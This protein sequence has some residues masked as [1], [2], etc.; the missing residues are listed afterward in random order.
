MVIGVLAL[1]GDFDAHRKMLEGCAGVTRVVPVRAPA[2]LRECDGLILPGG[3][4]T[5]MSRLCDRYG[6]W[7]PL[8][9]RLEQGMGALGTCAGL[10]LL[11]K[12]IEGG[13]RNFLQKT[14]G[15]LDVDVARNAYGAQLDSFEADVAFEGPSS[16]QAEPSLHAVF[17]RAPRI[18]RCGADVEVLATHNGEPVAVRQGN[19]MAA[20][21]H[22]EIAGDARLHQLWLKA[23]N[24]AAK[25]HAEQPAANDGERL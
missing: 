17:V 9:T 20:A 4:S 11:S 23:L 12:N 14:L 24:E 10:I 1:Q 8:S 22:P 18:T 5:V 21:F 13:S 15:A 7:E 2:D 6:L 25:K 19:L 16:A 3:E